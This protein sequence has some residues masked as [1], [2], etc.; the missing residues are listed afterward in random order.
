MSMDMDF[1]DIRPDAPQYEDAPLGAPES[2]EVDINQVI[3]NLQQG[4]MAQVANL[5]WTNAKITANAQEMERR[6]HEAEARAGAL[7]GALLTESE[8]AT[9]LEQQLS[10]SRE[11]ADHYADQMEKLQDASRSDDPP[12]EDVFQA[13]AALAGQSVLASSPAPEES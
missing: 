12:Q 4:W 6:W 13:A 10:T 9:Y 3:N 11:L 1:E 8:S 2:V 7:E 5:Q